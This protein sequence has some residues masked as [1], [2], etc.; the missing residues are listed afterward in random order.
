MLISYEH[1]FLKLKQILELKNNILIIS[2]RGP[3]GDTI[4]SNFALRRMLE[5]ELGKNIVSACADEISEKYN[6]VEGITNFVSDFNLNEFDL[7]ISVDIATESLLKFGKNK[8][9]LFNKNIPFINI[10]HHHDNSLF[11]TMNIV[12][13]EASTTVLLY[14]FFKWGNFKID[15]QIATY[16]L[17]GIYYD[18]G[19][20]MHSNTTPRVYRIV[21]DLILKGADVKLITKNLFNSTS[22]GKL[23]LWGRI[24]E[25]M[26]KDENNVILSAVLKEDLQ[27]TG[28]TKEDASGIIDYLNM[29][30]EAKFCMLLNESDQGLVKGSL[31]TLHD[32]VNV[33]EVAHK[34]GGGGHTKASGFAMSGK[35]KQEIRW[36]VIGE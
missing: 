19:S 2:H 17:L 13:G 18:T 35:L 32:D 5:L 6:F 16:L 26:Y 20:L 8:P 24:L 27:A 30:P 21:A 25:R 33:S 23:K 11:G 14:E 31:R 34:F 10:D 9:E 7:I 22:L 29:I 4:G 36:T 3:D 12:S 1:E 15:R 28:T